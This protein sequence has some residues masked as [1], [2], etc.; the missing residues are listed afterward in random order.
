MGARPR[1]NATQPRIRGRTL[2]RIRHH[3]FMLHPLCVECERQG[4][5]RLATQL[6]HIVALVNG[7]KDFDQDQGK[8][9]QGLCDEHHQDKTRA[10]LGQHVKKR[11]GPDGWP[12]ETDRSR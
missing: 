7:G 6:D 3:H 10:D 2:Q 5:V 9:R 8:N 1:S 12:V 11:I 4:F